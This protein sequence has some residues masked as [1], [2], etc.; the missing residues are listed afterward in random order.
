[1]QPFKGNKSLSKKQTKF[2]K[3]MRKIIPL[4]IAIGVTSIFLNSCTKEDNPNTN[5][6]EQGLTD[7][8]GNTYDSIVIG[9]QVWMKQNL[10]TTKYNDGSVIEN[11]PDTAVWADAL[12]GA[13]CNYENEDT[14]DDVY[15]KLYNW[16]AVNTGKLCPNGW[17]VATS[18]DWNVLAD[19]LGGAEIASDKLRETGDEHWVSPNTGATDE[20]D[21]TALP[22][23]IRFSDGVYF[24]GNIDGNWWTSTKDTSCPGNLN[25]YGVVKT[26]ISGQPQ[27]ISTAYSYRCG[28]SVRCIKN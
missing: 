17:H 20:V 12:T 6:S 23:G 13:F 18:N 27:I 8:D 11:V 14:L 28:L 5:K 16:Y 21:F 2:Y 15:G 24:L 9:N 26:M 7:G 10:K 25:K 22:G 4:F 3:A 19:Y 1:M